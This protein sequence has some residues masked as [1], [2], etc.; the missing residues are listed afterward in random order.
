MT[1][2]SLNTVFSL[3]GCVFLDPPHHLNFS[4]HPGLR[5]VLSLIFAFAKHLSRR[6]KKKQENTNKSIYSYIFSSLF[7]LASRVGPKAL[8]CLLE[9]LHP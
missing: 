4:Y 3:C 7:N 5:A 9:T 2:I 8:L 6:K 1:I